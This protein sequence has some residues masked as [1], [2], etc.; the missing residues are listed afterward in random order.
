MNVTINRIKQFKGGLFSIE[1]KEYLYIELVLNRSQEVLLPNYM[2]T[3]GREKSDS[4]APEYT[5]A[6]RNIC[7]VVGTSAATSRCIHDL[8]ILLGL[9]ITMGP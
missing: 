8:C 6:E 9:L 1:G 7:L 3:S 2:S 4:G 5:T